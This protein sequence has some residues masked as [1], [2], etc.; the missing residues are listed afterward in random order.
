MRA[1]Y[2][3]RRVPDPSLPHAPPADRLSWQIVDDSS[4]AWRIPL[5]AA[6][7]GALAEPSEQS[8]KLPSDAPAAQSFFAHLARRCNRPAA[9]SSVVLHANATLGSRRHEMILDL[10][11]QTYRAGFNCRDS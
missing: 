9:H 3:H 8:A 11:L 5:D 7:A 10:S 4:S 6:A 1:A 2:A